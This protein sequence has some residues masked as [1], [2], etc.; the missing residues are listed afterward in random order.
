MIS[1]FK[2]LLDVQASSGHWHYLLQSNFL[3]IK[4]SSSGQF[5]SLR[6]N[7]TV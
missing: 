1:G 2:E 7:G 3:G 5:P 4:A 6:R